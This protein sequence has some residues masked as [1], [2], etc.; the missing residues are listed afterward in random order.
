MNQVSLLRAVTVLLAV[1]AFFSVGCEPKVPS[2]RNPVVSVP[3]SVAIAEADRMAKEHEQEARSA[4]I[5]FQAAAKK[6]QSHAEI[7]LAELTA[8]HDEVVEKAN[9][10]AN[11]LREATAAAIKAAEERQSAILRSVGQVGEI[12]SMTGIPGIATFGGLLTG[13]VG[14]AS[15]W[16]SRQKASNTEQIA[17]RI[18][19][20]IDVLKTLSPEVAQALKT[21]G[22]TI[23]EWQ[24][25]QAVAFVNKTQVA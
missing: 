19:D 6:I 9:A 2:P 24:G 5:R 14:L 15:A 11:Q 25:P 12:A 20:S 10:Q 8:A 16:R 17:S 23:A 3:A 7:D 1:A 4:S 18:V 21:H 22:K 13:L